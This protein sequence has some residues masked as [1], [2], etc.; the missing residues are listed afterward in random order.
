MNHTD[1]VNLLRE[2]IPGSGGLW[3]DLGSGTGAFT[4]ALADLIGPGGEIHSVD[5]DRAALRQQE[6]AMRARFPE[7]ELH[8]HVADFSRQLDLPPLDGVVMANSLHFLRHKEP[9]LQLVHSYLRPAGRLI[10]VE[11]DTD[12]GNPWVPYPFSFRTWQEL[13]SRCSFTSTALLA[14]RPSRFLGHIYSAVSYTQRQ[15]SVLRQRDLPAHH[16]LALTRS[17]WYA[18]L[19]RFRDPSAIQHSQFSTTRARGA[20]PGSESLPAAAALSRKHASVAVP[21]SGQPGRYPPAQVRRKTIG[22][23]PVGTGGKQA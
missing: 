12:R 18:L 14:T 4:L 7:V 13:A 15:P 10:V 20:R 21:L 22:L 2:G 11:Y 9:V 6:G 16:L 23:V 1:H 5:K 3:A 8:L 19:G 17:S